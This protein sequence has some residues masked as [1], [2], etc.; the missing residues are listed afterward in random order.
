MTLSRRD[1]LKLTSAALAA[2]AFGQLPPE[3]I[4]RTQTGL[5]RVLT[6]G[7]SVRDAPSL[8]GHV[9]GYRT[10]DEVIPIFGTALDPDEARY[11]RAW[12]LTRD[13]FIHSGLVQPVANLINP[14]VDPELGRGGVV[15]RPYPFL[16]EVTVP[17]TDARFGPEDRG[18]V[19]YRMYYSTTHWVYDIVTGRD[20]LWW[21]RIFDDAKLYFYYVR[22]VHLRRV[23]PTE[24]TPLMPEIEDKRVEVDLSR[25]TVM[26]YAN[27]QPVMTT[28]VATGLPQFATPRGDW[29]VRRKR[30]SRHMLG[31][32]DPAAD[33]DYDL[34]GVPWVSYFM[35]GISFHGT[36]WHNDYG[37][38]RSHGCVNM[39]PQAAKW[40]YRWTLPVVP[41]GEQMVAG[42]GTQVI[43]F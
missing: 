33:P 36:Y 15:T 26:C 8:D 19:A 21:D 41:M 29:K 17:F 16:G 37:A 11:N 7:V 30:P 34:P 20:G 4:P 22:A 13:G 1:F 27:G 23:P 5:G 35:G 14:V 24:F 10:L 3:D 6:W 40:L 32:D 43:V 18:G 12:F 9:V 2:T 28:R 25:Q 39:T 31:Q 38:P 42:A